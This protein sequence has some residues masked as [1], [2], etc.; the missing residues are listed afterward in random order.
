VSL[1]V[2]KLFLFRAGFFFSGPSR[3][4]EKDRERRTPTK[5]RGGRRGGANNGY[6]RKETPPRV[7]NGGLDDSTF[8]DPMDGVIANGIKLEL[9]VKNLA[10]VWKKRQH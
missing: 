1:V 10:S 6:Q 4:D 5:G 2:S 8:D 9:L 3:E 7:G